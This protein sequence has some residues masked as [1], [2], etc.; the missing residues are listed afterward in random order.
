MKIIEINI[1]QFGKFKD[2]VFKLED[3]FNVVKG[4]N[5]SGKSTLLAFIKFA[6]YG[7]GRKNPSVA[8]GER[9]RA[10]SWNVGIAAGS[11][12][13]SDVDGKRYRIERVGRE[14]AKGSY[15]DKVRI[16]D[17]ENGEEVF[18]NEIPGEHFLGIDAQAYDSMCNIKQLEAVA[19]G[20]DAIK[21]VIDNLLS[22]GD[23]NMN[24]QSAIK[25]LDVERRRLLHTNGKGGLV[26]DSTVRLEKLKSEHKGAIISENERV[27]NQGELEGVE[28]ALAKAKDEFD[29]A[30]RMCDLHDDVLRLEKFDALKEYMDEAEALADRSKQLDEKA[31]FDLSR[32]NYD[33]AARIRALA[34]S[35]ERSKSALDSVTEEYQVCEA[36]YEKQCGADQK[37]FSEIIDEF[38][39]PSAAI[40]HLASKKKKRTNSALSLTVFSVIGSVLLIFAAVLALVLSNVAGAATVGFIALVLLILAGGSYK[41]FS[42][43]KAEIS[44]FMQKMGEGFCPK[45]EA[46][47][48]SSLEGFYNGIGERARLSNAKE[49]AKFRMGIA[50]ES[51]LAERSSILDTV[52]E[53]DSS[54]SDSEL[55]EYLLSLADKINEYL[56]KRGELDSEIRENQ[57]LTRALKS[58]LERFS[59]RDIRA[60]I[61]PEMVEK[62]KDI[63]FEKL[64]ADRDAALYKT[65]QFNQYKASIERNISSVSNKRSASD[66]FPEIVEEKERLSALKLRLDAIR[67]ASET[68]SGAST[69]LKSSV[70]PRIRERAEENLATVTDGKYSELYIDD[71]M[72]LSIFADGAT[73][74]IDSLSKGSLDAAYFSVRLA[75][76]QT[77]LAEKEPPL[78]M[79]ETLSQLDDNRAR[80]AIKVLDGYSKHA[81]C[82]LFTCQARDVELAKEISSIN[83]IEL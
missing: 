67:L 9:E 48:L 66:I 6:L 4:E 47:I 28:I 21:G 76:L 49:S 50:T 14:S 34:A 69:A 43:A 5:E 73:R 70:T 25:A 57:A 18:E 53:L 22:S 55:C 79:D 16:I 63:P 31:A 17:L 56:K 26:F 3:G 68:I 74:P 54:K 23:E 20:S 2:R 10:I 37:D 64:K 78:Y 44:A 33:F 32:A 41:K 80:N 51:H 60:K 27:K 40:T 72:G 65:N 75:L 24:I 52:S 58:E 29:V 61:N 82:V 62:I 36:A 59:E 8:V 15:S 35:L 77:L 42:R 11:L 45:D 46:R 19:I 81:Q 83:L 30:Q 12:S 1:I 39:T 38:G 71:N 7:V 13:I